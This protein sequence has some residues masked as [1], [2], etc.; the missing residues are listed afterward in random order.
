MSGERGG[1]GFFVASSKSIL[2]ILFV[3]VCKRDV[4]EPSEVA[5]VT[6]ETS[7]GSSCLYIS[8]G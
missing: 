5:L 3:C 6:V 1:G 7:H 4:S 2:E 8:V